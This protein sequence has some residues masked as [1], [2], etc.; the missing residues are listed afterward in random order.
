MLF[1]SALMEPSQPMYKGLIHDNNAG[2]GMKQQAPA[3]LK[4]EK[5]QLEN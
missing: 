4:K 5:K 3:A 1:L 2:K